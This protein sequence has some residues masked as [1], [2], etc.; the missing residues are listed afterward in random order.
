MS[1]NRYYHR[2]L[3][4]SKL[5]DIR[6]AYVPRNQTLARMIKLNKV[7][8]T[9]KFAS[10]G[11]REIEMKD[12]PQVADLFT[13]YMRRFDMSPIMSIDEIKHQFTSGLG[14]GPVVDGRREGQVV[15]TYVVE[16][17]SYPFFP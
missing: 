8:N 14:K 2:L 9:P 10:Q 5:V 15:W 17:E 11:L 7:A 1:I 4:V 3:N 6:F 13:R 12:I 16:V